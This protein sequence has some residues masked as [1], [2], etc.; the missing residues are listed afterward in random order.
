MVNYSTNINVIN[1]HLSTELT[2]HKK[3][4]P[5]RMLEIRVLAS[6]RHKN[7]ARLNKLMGSQ[8]SP[9]DNW[10][11]NDNTISIVFVGDQN[12]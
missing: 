2:E 1:N 10:M 6:D 12:K 9:L 8:P 4:P 5:H 11:F 3:G 7:G